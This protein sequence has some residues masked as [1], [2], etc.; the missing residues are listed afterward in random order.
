MN[1]S[2]R[3]L[4]LL[5]G[6]LTLFPLAGCGE[7]NK[8][9]E[10]FGE[11]KLKGQPVEEGVIQFVPIEN[12]PTGDGAVIR[13][14][15]YRIVKEKGLAPGKYRVCLYA[16]NG[17]SGAGDAS[18]DNPNAGKPMPKER[19]PPEYNAKSKLIAEVV[20]GKSNKFDYEIP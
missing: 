1:R 16:G 14:G 7:D 6:V 3:L 9:Q 11:V 18:P 17:L 15:Q 19:I 8:R 5:F 12:Q 20:G 2:A 10:I 4:Y 13:N